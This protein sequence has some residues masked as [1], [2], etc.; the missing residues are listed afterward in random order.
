MS[1]ITVSSETVNGKDVMMPVGVMYATRNIRIQGEQN[2]E[3]LV[4]GR[5]MVALT[6]AANGDTRTGKCWT[7]FVNKF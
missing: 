3:N 4:G 5:V 7:R 1:S 6:V 2:T